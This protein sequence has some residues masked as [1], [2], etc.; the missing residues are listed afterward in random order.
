MDSL[1]K[2]E[3][4]LNYDANNANIS[5]ASA[6]NDVNTNSGNIN[7]ISNANNSELV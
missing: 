5:S 2:L 4:S 1:P 6:G 7:S 3:K